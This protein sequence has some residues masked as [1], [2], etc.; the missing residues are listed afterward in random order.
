MATTGYATLSD[1]AHF[2]GW[3]EP[4][5]QIIEMQTQINKILQDM[6]FGP[7]TD[8]GMLETVVRTALPTVAWR[9]LNKGIQPD[10]SGTKNQT[11]TCGAMEALA[12]VDEKLLEKNGGI[13]SER[14]EKWRLGENQAYL[15]AMNNKTA[16]TLFY[17][18]E[19][20]NPA[21]FTGFGAYLYSLN[22]AK[23]SAYQQIIDAGG[24]GNNLTSMWFVWWD[25]TTVHGFFPEGTTGGWKYRDNGRVKAYDN[26]TPP[27]EFY[28]YESQ[29]NWDIGL[30]VRDYRYVVRIAN[31]DM[32]NA[33]I[34]AGL[35]NI[36]MAGYGQIWDPEFGKGA[37]YANRKLLIALNQQAQTSTNRAIDIA[38]VDGKPVT[39]FWGVPV[40]RVDAITST[41]SQI[42][43]A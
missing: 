20:V 12:K 15:Q 5:S 29:Y 8:G 19:R 41:E 34:M 31:I 30:A 42:T 1:L 11:F 28:A 24:T 25:Q 35:I 17:G 23:C 3:D 27:G 37:I 10:K 7:A 6:I 13:G 36:M 39:S 9:M 33:T 26:Q 21:G 22:P 40:R 16:T 14:A 38:V 43:V 4:V 18:D 32:T 2:E